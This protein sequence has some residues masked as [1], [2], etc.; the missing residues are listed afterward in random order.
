MAYKTLLTEVDEDAGVALITLNRPES[1]NALCEEMM[2]ELSNAL[3]RFEADEEIGCI[4]LTGGKKAFSGGAD[5][6][7]IQDKTF[8]E[9]YYEDFISRNWERAAHMRKPV[10]AAVS[11]YA[12][13]GGCEL[14]LMC[15]I[16]L[17]ADTARFGQP[18]VRLGVIPGAGGTQRL[19]RM[20][21]KSK[22]MELCLT[23]RMMEAKEAEMC[24]L[25]SRVVPA[26]D[27]LDAA[28]ELARTIASMPLASALMIKEAVNIAYETPLSQGIQF[29]RRL[30]QSLFSTDD[31]KEGMAAYI[32]KRSAHFKDK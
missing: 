15:D 4:I 2:N 7:E 6:K 1:L 8:P 14:A 17:A 25:V 29:E 23:G 19:A 27:L 11:G 22:T 13:G 10:I 16:I 30:F 3:D 20:I 26:D 9:S 24:G 18:E 31:Q 5:I 12:I 32:E 21:G 28:R